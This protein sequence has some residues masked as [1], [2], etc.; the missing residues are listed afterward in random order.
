MMKQLK[1]GTACLLLLAAACGDDFDAFY[2]AVY[3]VV[4]VEAEITLPDPE[5][6]PTDPTDP[7]DPTNPTDPTEPETKAGENET[8]PVVERIREEIEAAA[9]VKAGGSYV[10]EFTKHNGGRLRIRQTAEADRVR[11]VFFKDPGATDILVYCP[12][13]AMKYTC[14]VSAYKAEDGTSKTL[15]TVDLTE[16]YQALYPEAGITKAVRREYTSANAK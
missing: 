3:P 12:E 8:D 5:P 9:P 15:L 14:A 13:P 10:L 4:R 2:T 7:T 1:Y 16:E 11:G 6:G